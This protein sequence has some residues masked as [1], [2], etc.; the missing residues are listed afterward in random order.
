M[1]THEKAKGKRLEVTEMR[2]NDEG[3]PWGTPLASIVE[4]FPVSS[5]KA[6]PH[7]FS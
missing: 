2:N 4:V 1:A 7:F 6:M 3:D 5:P